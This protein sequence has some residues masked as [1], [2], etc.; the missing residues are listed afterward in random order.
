MEVYKFFLFTISDDQIEQKGINI[1]Q[2]ERG[3]LEGFLD[4]TGSLDHRLIVDLL[5][6]GLGFPDR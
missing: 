1:L 6:Q 5:K 3:S 4:V 2:V